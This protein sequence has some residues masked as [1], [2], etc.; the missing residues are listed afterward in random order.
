MGEDQPNSSS[1]SDRS[2]HAGQN[3]DSVFCTQNRS[4][5]EEQEEDKDSLEEEESS[6]ARFTLQELRDVLHER[7]ELKAQ[8]FV[9]QEELTYYKRYVHD[10]NSLNNPDRTMTV[11]HSCCALARRPKR[12]STLVSVPPLL[13][14]APRLPTAPNQES[15][16][17]ES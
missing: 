1:V 15:D 5:G 7:N 10:G 12:S 2:C 17:C 13:R 8:V 4:T 16:A 3:A 9:L 11:M 14:R 6:K